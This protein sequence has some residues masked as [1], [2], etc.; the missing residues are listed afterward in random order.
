MPKTKNYKFFNLPEEYSIEDYK[1]AVD[2]IIKKYSKING[3][4]SVYNWGNPSIPGISDIDM[5][6]VFKSSRSD[7]LPLL[8]RSFYFLDKKT[9]YLVA[10]PFIFIEEDSFKGVRHIY[11]NTD[12]K[13]LHGR[14]IKIEKLSAD[15]EYYS[16]ID[17]L[18]DIVIRHYPRDFIEQFVPKKINV[19]TLY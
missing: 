14:D 17:L 3:L 12:F 4:V 18:N 13:L 2:Y 10:H 1:D 9:R 5:L 15:D 19:E 6:F 8:N 11:P 16:K 7:S